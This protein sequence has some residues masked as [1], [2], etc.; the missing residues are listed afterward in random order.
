MTTLAGHHP[1]HGEIACWN[2]RVTETWSESHQRAGFKF[3]NSHNR[4][5]LSR[6]ELD[7]PEQVQ[8]ESS[9]KYHDH[10]Q[11]NLLGT[12]FPVDTPHPGEA[13]LIVCHG[14]Q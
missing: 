1:E 3:S 6:D 8:H 14:Q 13:R 2:V 11:T 7:Q 4:D 12:A 9:A 10:S 5:L